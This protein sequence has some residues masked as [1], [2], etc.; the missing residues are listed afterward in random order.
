MGFG[1]GG[2]R[3]STEQGYFVWVDRCEIMVDDGLVLYIRAHVY[4]GLIK[5]G[6]RRYVMGCIGYELAHEFTDSWLWLF[7]HPLRKPIHND[8]AL[9]TGG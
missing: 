6:I 2:D 7:S 5:G 1:G 9:L 4:T 3:C 8:S